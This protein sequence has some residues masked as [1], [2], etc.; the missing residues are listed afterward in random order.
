MAQAQISEQNR[1]LQ[2][3]LNLSEG[4]TPFPWQ[5]ELLRRFM[6]GVVGRSLDI[7][8]TA[9]GNAAVMAIWLVARAF[10]GAVPRRLVCV[11]DR[12]G[13]DGV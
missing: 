12:R 6:S 8:P 1:W 7:L 11:V 13:H 4:E 5:Q 3:A 9:L 2:K 10:G